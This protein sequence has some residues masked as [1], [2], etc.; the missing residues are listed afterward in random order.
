[1][2]SLEA[3]II[4]PLI[5]ILCC[6]TFAGILISYIQ[7]DRYNSVYLTAADKQR[8]EEK[9][10]SYS[11]KIIALPGLK[12]KNLAERHPKCVIVDCRGNYV[13]DIIFLLKDETAEVKKFLKAG[14]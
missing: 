13:V 5:I 7:C 12:A 6:L 10:L 14:A 1:M 8:Q 3:A 4:L 11:S 2:K 9:M